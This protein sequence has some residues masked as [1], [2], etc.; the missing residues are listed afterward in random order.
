MNSGQFVFPETHRLET[1]IGD[2]S[3]DEITGQVHF[4]FLFPTICPEFQVSLNRIS[5]ERGCY[6]N[7][8]KLRKDSNI[9][10]WMN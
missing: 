3:P 8:D 1:R 5:M 9:K 6:V 4:I 7:A 10:R 2:F